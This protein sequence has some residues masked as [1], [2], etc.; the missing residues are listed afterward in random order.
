MMGTS[1][2]NKTQKPATLNNGIVKKGFIRVGTLVLREDEDDNYLDECS[3]Y[4]EVPGMKI[5]YL[6][7]FSQ[8]PSHFRSAL[9]NRF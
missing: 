5:P 6:W 7:Q 3:R 8:L 4:F 2:K 1:I 9:S